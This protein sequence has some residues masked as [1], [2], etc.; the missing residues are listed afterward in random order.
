MTDMAKLS[1]QE[2]RTDHEASGVQRGRPPPNAGKKDDWLS[3]WRAQPT[4]KPAGELN[5]H[6][7]C[8]ESGMHL[9]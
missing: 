3:L 2:I 6:L 4:P 8:A 1:V 7:T 9:N 5:A